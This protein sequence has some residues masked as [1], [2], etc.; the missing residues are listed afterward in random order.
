MS[1]DCLSE[2]LYKTAEE[3]WEHQSHQHPFLTELKQGTSGSGSF[4]LLFQAG[5]C[6]SDRLCED[7]RLSVV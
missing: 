4:H 7:V 3:I 6:V 5:L 1:V 2:R